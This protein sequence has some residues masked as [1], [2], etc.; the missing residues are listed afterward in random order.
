MKQHKPWRTSR[1]CLATVLVG[2]LAAFGV[3][4][5]QGALAA[6]NAQA[7]LQALCDA[8]FVPGVVLCGVGLLVFVANDG[9]FDMINYGVL[10]VVKLIQSEE[11]R[12]AFPKTFYDYKVLKSGARS[13]STTWMIWVGAGFILVAA[14]FLVCYLNV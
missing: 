4:M 2:L 5:Q 8:F 10:K 1:K 13:G 6:E 7:W 11:K 9:F 14:V 12:A 3:L